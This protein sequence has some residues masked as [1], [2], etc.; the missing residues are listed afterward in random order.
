[1]IKTPTVGGALFNAG[2]L[3]IVK[4]ADS[5]DK[6]PGQWE[7]PRGHVERGESKENALVRE[8]Q[9]EVGLTVKVID[10]YFESSFLY[11]NET[12]DESYYIVE[13]KKFDIKLDPNEHSQFKWITKKDLKS[14][15]LNKE[16]QK[17]M[18]EA[19]NSGR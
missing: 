2:K 17:A 3:L 8:F 13:A 5:E 15:N 6:W 18:I 19:F 4:R 11:V 14:L 1:M 9:E 7:I 10:K 16:M 12:V